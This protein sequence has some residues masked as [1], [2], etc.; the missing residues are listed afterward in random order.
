MGESKLVLN[1]LVLVFNTHL[2]AAY[3]ITSLSVLT[4]VHRVDHIRVNSFTNRVS[5]IQNVG[6]K[7]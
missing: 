5:F 7:F 6:S 4:H 1:L 2:L 3:T